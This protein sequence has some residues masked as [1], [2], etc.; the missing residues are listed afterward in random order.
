MNNAYRA[1]VT[2]S[3]TSKIKVETRGVQFSPSLK[4]G[5]REDE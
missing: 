3:E 4:M 2:F 1:I 5:L